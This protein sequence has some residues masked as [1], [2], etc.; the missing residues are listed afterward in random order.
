LVRDLAGGRI[1]EGVMECCSRDFPGT[2]RYAC[3]AVGNASYH[4]SSLYPYL[5]RVIPDLVYAL[6]AEEVKT[7]INAAGALGNLVRNSEEL[8]G[9]LIVSDA[10]SGLVHNALHDP[11]VEARRI[12]LYSIGNFCGHE[13]HRVEINE[14][15]GRFRDQ[16][17]ALHDQCQDEKMK[18]NIQRIFQKLSRKNDFHQQS[19]Y[20]LKEHA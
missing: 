9:E 15:E 11:S 7:R 19:A 3:F 8:C 16:L 13:V 18:I 1:I 14:K 4:D 5:R 17:E 6:S 10:L 2:R 12:T 20:D